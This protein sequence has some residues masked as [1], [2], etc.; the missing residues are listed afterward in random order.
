MS[1]MAAA[2][3]KFEENLAKAGRNAHYHVQ[4][5]YCAGSPALVPLGQA[6][7]CA[8]DEV[9]F[10][11]MSLTGCWGEEKKKLAETKGLGGIV[12]ARW[13]RGKKVFRADII[14]GEVIEE[15]KRL[16]WEDIER[17]K[18][19]RN[20]KEYLDNLRLEERRELEQL[21]FRAEIHR[22]EIK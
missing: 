16:Q 11:E 10:H 5:R 9:E 2:Y 7:H 19:L 6:L 8:D 18:A 13:E 14:T 4:P 21:E 22:E 15:P 1:N 3:A 12:Y 20:R 17:L